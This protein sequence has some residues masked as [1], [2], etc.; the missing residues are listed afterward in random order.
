MI[1]ELNLKDKV[2]NIRLTF[3]DR[4]TASI[5]KECWLAEHPVDEE[6]NMVDYTQCPQCGFTVHINDKKCPNCLFCLTCDSSGSCRI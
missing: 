4:L 3:E 5:Y 6:S 2:L 1:S